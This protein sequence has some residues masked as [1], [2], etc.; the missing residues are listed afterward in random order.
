MP[1]PSNISE[2]VGD[3]AIKAK[4]GKTWSQWI[5]LLDRAKSYEKPHK[6]IAAWLNRERGLSPWWSQTVTVGYEQA[7][8]LRVLHQKTNG[9]EISVSRTL[10][11]ST[12]R[13]FTAWRNVRSRKRFLD[14]SLTLRTATSPKSLRFNRGDETMIEIRIASK[15]SDKCQVAVQHFKLKTASSA[16][17]MKKYWAKILDSMKTTLEE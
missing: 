10:S 15:G 16:A 5:A 6:E 17:A 9:F 1:K 14:E 8:G 11:V 7:K 4:T 3:N 13:A 12:T 2:R